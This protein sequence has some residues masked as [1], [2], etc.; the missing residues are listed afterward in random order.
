MELQKK[1]Q[2]HFIRTY[3]HSNFLPTSDKGTKE[4]GAAENDNGT[5]TDV[6][7]A[8]DDD[9]EDDDRTRQRWRWRWWY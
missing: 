4:G 6:G 8:D 5:A 2:P 9:E 7:D 1:G 3:I